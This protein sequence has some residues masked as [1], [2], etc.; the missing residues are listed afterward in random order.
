VS[1]GPRFASHRNLLEYLRTDFVTRVA[2]L[3]AESKLAPE[4]DQVDVDDEWHEDEDESSG[5]DSSG[6][7]DEFDSDEVEDDEEIDAET[8]GTRFCAGS[9]SIVLK[10][11]VAHDH[12]V[13]LHC[14]AAFSTEDLH[15]V[16]DKDGQLRPPRHPAILGSLPRHLPRE[17]QLENS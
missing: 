10:R 14:G 15:E 2:E 6:E 3:V 11:D 4:A 9:F 16:D 7:L 17:V 13:C 5:T 12:I 8:A 1:P